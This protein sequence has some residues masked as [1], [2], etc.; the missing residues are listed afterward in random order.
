MAGLGPAPVLGPV[1]VD[2]RRVEKLLKLTFISGS[3]VDDSMNSPRL[4]REA[5]WGRE[6]LK[7]L[8]FIQVGRPDLA[9]I[10][11]VAKIERRQNVKSLKFLSVLARTSGP[12]IVNRKKFGLVPAEK[13]VL[14]IS[15][16]FEIK[17]TRGC[18]LNKLVRFEQSYISSRRIHHN[19]C[20]VIADIGLIHPSGWKFYIG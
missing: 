12:A 6:E 17:R 3:G 11:R 18:F 10:M 7:P 8:Y 4:P 2:C 1:A 20:R 5:V 16:A 15:K 19:R 14:L 9:N 13:F